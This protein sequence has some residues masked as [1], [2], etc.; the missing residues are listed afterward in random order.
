MGTGQ[1][2]GML[3][4]I[5]R[6]HVLCVMVLRDESVVADSVGVDYDGLS[7]AS[8]AWEVPVA[9]GTQWL[10]TIVAERAGGQS[11]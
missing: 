6:A 2:A 7:S 1:G 5:C 3:V 11:A 8:H 10:I 4:F 9:A